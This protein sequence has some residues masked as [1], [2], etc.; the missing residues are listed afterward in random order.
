MCRFPNS[1]RW[2]DVDRRRHFA[3]FVRTLA[4]GHSQSWCWWGRICRS[5]GL[6]G[7]VYRPPFAA[8]ARIIAAW[9][10]ES[11]GWF[12]GGRF[13]MTAIMFARI[14]DHD[15]RIDGSGVI[16]VIRVRYGHGTVDWR[17]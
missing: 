2:L 15:S 6:L 4:A 10:S 11:G 16:L 3:M 9:H 7:M 12:C 5:G 14:H 8:F 1:W 13:A 17:R